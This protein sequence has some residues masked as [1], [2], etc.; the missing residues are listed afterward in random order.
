MRFWKSFIWLSA[1]V[2]IAAGSAGAADSA[3]EPPAPD[4]RL[5]KTELENFVLLSEFEIS[6]EDLLDVRRYLTSVRREV[7]RDFQFF[8]Q[9]RIEVILSR[10]QTFR[11]YTD[12]PEHVTGYFDGR[13]HLPVPSAAESEASLKAVLWHEYTHAVVYLLSKNRCPTWLHEGFARYE[14]AKVKTPDLAVLRAALDK[15]PGLPLA[16]SE[17]DGAMAGIAQDP[18]GAALVYAQAHGLVDYLFSRFS[19][20]DMRNFLDALGKG[21]AVDEALRRIFH[22]APK[23]A[24]AR[25]N[26][27]LRSLA[28]R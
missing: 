25:W 18:Q 7:G 12:L 20:K 24:E 28:G 17:L 16:M 23:E 26:A 2:W 5:R 11:H 22:L 13:I 27:H 15:N 21:L 9:N 14:E 4:A 6:K 1:A 10:E 8:P 3:K 19:N